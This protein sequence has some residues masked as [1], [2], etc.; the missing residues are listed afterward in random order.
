VIDTNAD[1]REGE[2]A[3]AARPLASWDETLAM[4]PPP[5]DSGELPAGTT[6]GN[7]RVVGVLGRG[8]M[9]VVYEAED[10]A[11]ARAVAIKVLPGALAHNH[12]ALERFLREARTAARLVHPNVVPI[13]EV[14]RSGDSHYLVMQKLPG[15]S[16]ADAMAAGPLPWREATRAVAQ[17]C[18]GLAAAHRAG[19]LHRDIKP[20]N[21]LRDA[22]GTVKL[23]DFGLAKAADADGGLQLTQAGRVVGTP[24]YMSPEQCHAEPLDA[25]SDVY[26]L[27]ATYYGLLTGRGPYAESTSIPKVMYAHC[28]QPPPDPREAVPD[29]PEGCALVV[30]RA[31]AKS[32]DDRYPDADALRADLEALLGDEAP[33]L[34]SSSLAG[35]SALRKAGPARWTRRAAL[36]AGAAGVLGLCGGAWWLG[37][38][39]GRREGG[40]AGSPAGRAAARAGAPAGPPIRVGVLCSE[41]GP[42]ALSEAGVIDGVM[43][44]I[45]ELNA[46]G[47]VLGRPVEG[48]HADGRS[49]PAAFAREAARLIDS[50]AVAAIFGCWTSASRKAVRPVV[51]ERDHVLFYPVQSEGLEDSPHIIYLGAAPNQQLLPA[52]KWAY[53]DIGRRFFHVG[54]D[55][56]FPRAAGAVMRDQIEA[57]GGSLV[58]ESFRPLRAV[59]FGGVVEAI[60]AARPD[61]ILNTINGDG[62][63]AFFHALRAAGITSEAIPTISFS[64]AE[65]EVRRLGLAEMAGDLAAWNYFMAIPGPENAAFL[66]RFRARYGARRVTS[67]PIEAA[68]VGVHLWAKAAAKAGD[69]SPAAVR[70]SIRG[71]GFDAPGGPVRVDPDNGHLWKTARIARLDAEGQFHMVYSS[72]SPI[73]PRPF[74]PSRTRAEWEALLRSLYDGWGGR[75][76]PASG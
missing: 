12:A 20:A 21:L 34:A 19:L 27:G 44:A 42:M 24:A 61:V 47:G 46:A 37:R 2:G 76:A 51:E 39:R 73:E 8:G 40:A 75:W 68:Y 3:A 25:R 52:V 74:P 14:G 65:P 9:G 28:Y 5:D 43:L 26:S 10:V 45:D 64:I 35:V 18:R 48:V 13:F 49:D 38:R 31:M 17:A 7:H 1:G 22:D 57:L 69:A 4:N 53:T 59:D 32:P 70:A 41:S 30:A 55:Y 67:D 54:S 29:V 56:V 50:E 62:N 60:A 23:T 6:L 15:G 72:G 58:G 36:G 11:L 71:L 16:L 66:E 63:L 33:P